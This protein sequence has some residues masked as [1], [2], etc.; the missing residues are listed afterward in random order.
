MY[1]LLPPPGQFSPRAEQQQYVLATSFLPLTPARRVF[2]MVSEKLKRDIQ[3]EKVF[4]KD[5]YNNRGQYDKK[6][7][8]SN[9]TSHQLNILIKILELIVKG[10]IPI[11]KELFPAIKKSKR[12]PHLAKLN[13]R[14]HLSSLQSMPKEQKL[15]YLNQI[16][17]YKELLYNL[18]NLP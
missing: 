11:K 14:F 13:D 17:T 18:F 2:N 10:E 15:L 9:A 8:L 6:K 12:L 4:L 3:G 1:L 7:I 5:I 16:S